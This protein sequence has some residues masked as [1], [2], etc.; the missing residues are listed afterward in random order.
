MKALTILNKKD[1]EDITPTHVI[2]AQNM[3]LMYH[4]TNGAKDEFTYNVVCKTGTN[5]KIHC[6][7]HKRYTDL[8]I[9]VDIEESEK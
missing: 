5:K 7:V 1:N 3:Y 4:S 9:T 2:Y 6:V 8:V